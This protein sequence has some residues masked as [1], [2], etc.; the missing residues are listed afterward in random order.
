MKNLH[1]LLYSQCFYTIKEKLYHLKFL[2]ANA[3]N[4]DKLENFV[5]LQGVNPSLHIS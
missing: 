3:I 2:S 5:G 1:F 4:L